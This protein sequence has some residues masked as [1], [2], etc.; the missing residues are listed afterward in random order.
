MNMDSLP[1][2]D[3][4]GHTVTNTRV[5]LSEPLHSGLGAG[6]FDGTAFLK[7]DDG[8]ANVNRTVTFECT[9]EKTVAG[10]MALFSFIMETGYTR[11]WYIAVNDSAIYQQ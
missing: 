4:K 8:G 6:L 11:Y 10:N 9:F 5:G 2:T 1:F 3:L 7:V